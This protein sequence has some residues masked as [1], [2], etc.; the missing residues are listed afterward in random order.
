MSESA[1][2]KFYRSW[3]RSKKELFILGMI[4]LG[5]FIV[6]VPFAALGWL[7]LSMGWLLGAVLSLVS[8]LTMHRSSSLIFN[9]QTSGKAGGILIAVGF[10]SLRF[11]LWIAG[12]TVAAICTFKVDWFNG[13]DLFYFWTT[14]AAYAI[15]MT[16]TIVFSVIERK[17]SADGGQQ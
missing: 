13:F 11:L 16:V 12:L 6:L 14:L 5:V 3:D 15:G 1:E 4:Y 10:S 9:S 17:G 7:R 8:N 2:K